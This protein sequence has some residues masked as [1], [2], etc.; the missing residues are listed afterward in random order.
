MVEGSFMTKFFKLPGILT[1]IISVAP[2]LQNSTTFYRERV[3]NS[4]DCFLSSRVFY[5]R[6]EDL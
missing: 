6:E 5:R 3:F 1:A 2:V 4:M